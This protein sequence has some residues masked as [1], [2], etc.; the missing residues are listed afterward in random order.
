MAGRSETQIDSA[1]KRRPGVPTWDRGTLFGQ[2]NPIHVREAYW[3]SSPQRVQERSMKKRIAMAALIG[4]AVGAGWV[5][6]LDA[7]HIP[8]SSLTSAWN[9]IM[10][11]SCPSIGAIRAAWW[12]VPLLNSILYAVIGL[13]VLFVR[14][15]IRPFAK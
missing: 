11:A 3:V 12:L 1:V 8:G 9:A 6:V 7:G 15:F 5:L 4:A 10:W 13:L 14:K 2:A